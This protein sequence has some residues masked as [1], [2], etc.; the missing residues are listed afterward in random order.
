MHNTQPTM[1]P[2]NPFPWY[3]HMRE[4]NPVYFDEETGGWHVFTY[5]DVQRV[6]SDY[7][8]FSSQRGRDSQH[9]ENPLGASMISQD[10]PR[11]RQLRTLA[12]QAFTPRAVAQ[13]E[14]RITAIT[15][16]LLDAV[17]AQGSMDVIADLAVPLPVIVIAEMLGIP[18]ADRE[19]FKLWSDAIVQGTHSAAAGA[20]STSLGANW[21]GEMMAYFQR[22]IALR[23]QEPRDDLIT[24]LLAAQTDGQHLTMS[25]VLGFCI[26]LLIAGNET[27]T[28][29]IG[30]AILCFNEHPELQDRLRQA[31]ELLPAALEEVLRY[32][33]PVQSMFRVTTQPVELS[34]QT[35]PANAWVTA[36]IGSANRD[37]A[38]FP[39]PDRFDSTRTPNRHIA[40]G[41]GIH[42]CLG[43]PLARLEARVALNAMLARL[44]HIRLADTANLAALGGNIVFG[45]THLPITFEQY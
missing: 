11:H 7:D 1:S 28:N 41:Y 22:M 14:P 21:Y 9:A 20:A 43:A 40:F 30:N 39:E 44:R 38:Q 12:T 36:W 5:S 35:I 2:L 26:L 27:T 17:A 15:N 24:D 34:G 25:E 29:L 42:F 19:R 31:P 23:Q 33:S 13:L 45:V 32:R 18:V 6:L 8:V 4:H 10:P 37:P 3:A 16:A